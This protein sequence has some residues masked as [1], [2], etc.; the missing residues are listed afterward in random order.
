MATF[1]E[2]L[3][4]VRKEKKLTL[5]ELS[6]IMNISVSFISHYE[7]DDR[8][9][10]PETIEKFKEALGCSFEDLGYTKNYWGL[11]E[12]LTEEEIKEK[13]SNELYNI[14]NDLNEDGLKKALE[15]ALDLRDNPKYKNNSDTNLPIL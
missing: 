15:Y 1:G 2:N 12:E 8:K 6:N 14:L 4:R 9:P 10:K 3:K 7:H 5:K 13:N 11:V